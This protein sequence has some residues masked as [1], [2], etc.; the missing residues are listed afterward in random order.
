M[1]IFCSN[2]QKQQP[3]TSPSRKRKYCKYCGYEI[4][5]KRGDKMKKDNYNLTD[6]QYSDILQMIKKT[7][8]APDFKP[9]CYDDTSMGSKYTHS[10]CGF[11]NDGYA[12]K[13]TA[14]FPER[15]TRHN[16][17]YMK[18]QRKNHKCP[19]DLRPP[20][21]EIYSYKKGKRTL[22]GMEKTDYSWS[23]FYDCFIFG[24][25]K[26]FEKLNK[27]ST[28]VKYIRYLVSETIKESEE[29]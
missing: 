26:E 22:K 10:N 7:V 27:K 4:N 20:V 18:D 24:N 29:K 25:S 2:C 13:E 11:C 8:E 5:N 9:E 21:K 3:I 14:I 1:K 6:K 23:C 12:T 19:F 17:Y 16:T 28:D 15:R